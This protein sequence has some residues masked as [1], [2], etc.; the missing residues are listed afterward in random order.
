[1]LF[2][3]SIGIIL[4]FLFS[5][6]SAV[7]NEWTLRVEARFGNTS[8]KVYTRQSEKIH[9]EAKIVESDILRMKDFE[10]P[11]YPNNE[12]L[13]LNGNFQFHT[14]MGQVFL[15]YSFTHHNSVSVFQI[16]DLSNRQSEKILT[17][18]AGMRRKEYSKAT[19][20]PRKILAK[21]KSTPELPLTDSTLIAIFNESY[22]IAWSLT[23]NGNIKS[24]KSG[25]KNTFYHYDIEKDEIYKLPLL[26]E[27]LENEVL[28][29]EGPLSLNP[30]DVI[31]SDDANL[32]SVYQSIH[33]S[34]EGTWHTVYSGQYEIGRYI[35]ISYLEDH[36]ADCH[37]CPV[38]VKAD[39]FMTA[40]NNPYKSVHLEVATVWGSLRNT[41][42][43]HKHQGCNLLSYEF[44]NG[45]QG[46]YS[47]RLYFFDLDNFTSKPITHYDYQTAID[48]G[49]Y[50]DE[51]PQVV[52]EELKQC[53]PHKFTEPNPYVHFATWFTPNYEIDENGDLILSYTDNRRS[54]EPLDYKSCREFLVYTLPDRTV[55][56]S[57]PKKQNSGEI[58]EVNYGPRKETG[59]DLSSNEGG[60]FFE[61]ILKQT[62]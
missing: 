13:L 3:R 35:R 57:G 43:I 51:I 41:F 16:F 26:V 38:K 24:E 61:E 8:Y 37:A 60:P 10:Y 34:H 32:P 40:Q 1:M 56:I 52:Q 15:G 45:G 17:V 31:T 9:D 54:F 39:F 12:A 23:A 6:V 58:L 27:H 50:F 19:E 44:F 53:A 29:F 2:T 21:L 20:I 11:I 33:T 4:C 22:H 28:F 36:L 42:Q 14:I 7:G 25:R 62:N 49:A 30:G 18:H 59:F 48:R 5:T 55:K 46:N 47:S